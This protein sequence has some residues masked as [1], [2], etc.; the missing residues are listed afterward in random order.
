MHF[1]LSSIPDMLK[2][3]SFQTGPVTLNYAEGPEAGPPLLLLHGMTQRWQG[4]LP[5]IPVLAQTHHVYAIDFRGHGKSSR[6]KGAYRGEDYSR[7]VLEFLDTVVG[8]PAIIFGHSLGGMVSLYLSATYPNR[9]RAQAI[10]DSKIFGTDLNGTV[11]PSMFRQVQEIMTSAMSFDQLC[12]VIPGMGIESPVFGRIP[13]KLLPGCDDA[14]LSAWA[15]SLSQL[16]PDVLSMTL[17]GRAHEGWNP[18]EL[19]PK[20]KCPTL[21]IQADPKVGALMTDKDIEL[22]RAACPHVQVARLNGIGHSLHMYQ[23]EPVARALINFL[24]SLE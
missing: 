13:M 12:R 10:G 3:K 9:V 18:A 1:W 6:M 4:F 17:D 14:Y 11:M 8:G 16:D 20:I 24:S 5:L 22:A 7:D 23:V 2:E 15:R 21:M 19:I